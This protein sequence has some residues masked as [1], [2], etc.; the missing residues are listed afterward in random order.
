MLP[1][2]RPSSFGRVRGYFEARW[3]MSSVALIGAVQ[4]ERKAP[5]FRRCG[6]EREQVDPMWAACAI[7]SRR[8][9]CL[10]EGD[11]GK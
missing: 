5:S 9:W 6:E 10:I 2:E 4:V 7:I 1:M 8:T 11:V 3:K